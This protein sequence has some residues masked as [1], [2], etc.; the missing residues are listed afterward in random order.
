MTNKTFF[1]KEKL[2]ILTIIHINGIILSN[3]CRHCCQYRLT[4][5]TIQEQKKNSSLSG[6]AENRTKLLHL[7]QANSLEVKEDFISLSVSFL[8]P[9]FPTVK[10]IGDIIVSSPGV[11]TV[12]WKPCLHTSP[13]YFFFQHKAA[14][15]HKSQE[16]MGKHHF[17]SS[18]HH[19][20]RPIDYSTDAIVYVT[21]C[22][23]FPVY[24]SIKE[25][26]VCYLEQV[27]AFPCS[28]FNTHIYFYWYHMQFM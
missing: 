21:V 16:Q 14:S 2:F 8:S 6:G 15:V 5:R 23:F 20:G 28:M 1:W 9:F 3:Y 4:W 25:K 12:V 17:S 22:N 13:E 18:E 26:S 11:N 10:N 27:T 7:S 24:K 19:I